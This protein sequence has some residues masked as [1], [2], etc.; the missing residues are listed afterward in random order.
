MMRSRRTEKFLWSLVEVS[1]EDSG[2]E[3]RY[4]SLCMRRIILLHEDCII[5]LLYNAGYYRL[6]YYYIAYKN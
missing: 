3:R 4:H 5:I 2:L 1:T 6:H